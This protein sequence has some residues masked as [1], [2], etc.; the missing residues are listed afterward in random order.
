MKSK[1][2]FSNLTKKILFFIMVFLIIPFLSGRFFSKLNFSVEKTIKATSNTEN[3]KQEQNQELKGIWFSYLEWAK[4]HGGKNKQEWIKTINEQIIP[5]LKKF[6]INNVF[7]HAVAH[8][9]AMYSSKILP[10]SNVVA[11]DFDAPLDYDPFLVFVQLLKQNQIKVHAWINPLR[12]M[13]DGDFVKIKDSYLSKQWFKSPNQTDYY[14]KDKDAIYWLNPANKKTINFVKS[15]VEEILTKYPEIEGIH[16]DDYFYPNGLHNNNVLKSDLDYYKKV[17]PPLDIKTFRLNSVT[18]LCKNL[19]EVCCK[20]NKIFGIS[21]QGNIKNNK[22]HMFFNDEEVIAKGYLHY[23]MPQ[24]Y[25]GFENQC[26][27]FKE[28]VQTW[29]NLILKNKPKDKDIKFYVG[30]PF[31]KCGRNEDFY[32]GTG[33][34]EWKT[35]NDIIKRQ[36]EFLKE[37]KACSGFVFF[38]YSSLCQPEIFTYNQASKEIAGQERNNVLQILK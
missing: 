23:I 35:K 33:R 8:L 13:R 17:N 32:A 5:N 16:L 9:D 19:Y 6:K 11:K 14:I 38:S 18:Q 28:S 29:Y 4:L 31:H 27:P 10:N 1:I 15:F 3:L 36:I 34:F 2:K 20:H 26:C 7:L 25:Y 24:L 22:D 12:A 37:F 30:L 21:P